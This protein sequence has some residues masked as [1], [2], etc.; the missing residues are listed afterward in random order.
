[1]DNLRISFLLFAIVVINTLTPYKKKVNEGFDVLAPFTAMVKGIL[2]PVKDFYPT[3]IE[4]ETL[5]ELLVSIFVETFTTLLTIIIYP[6]GPV[7]IVILFCI[8]ATYCYPMIYRLLTYK[9]V[10]LSGFKSQVL[11]PRTDHIAQIDLNNT[12]SNVVYT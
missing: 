9:Y 6:F 10:S 12:K 2:T 5:P 1:M 7:G 4:K 3:S 11:G 8:G